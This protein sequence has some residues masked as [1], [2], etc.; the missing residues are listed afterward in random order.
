MMTGIRAATTEIVCSI[1][2]D[3]TYDPRQLD[4]MV[5]LLTKSVQVVTA[6]PYHPDG[7]ALNLPGTPPQK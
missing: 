2:S 1:D 6:S 7:H 5:R 4:A 3:C